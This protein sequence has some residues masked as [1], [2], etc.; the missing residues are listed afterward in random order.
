MKTLIF[1]LLLTSQL[2]AQSTSPP[3]V[4]FIGSARGIGIVDTIKTGDSLKT[5]ALKTKQ[6]DNYLHIENISGTGADTFVVLNRTYGKNNILLDEVQIRGTMTYDGLDYLSLVVPQGEKRAFYLNDR[7]LD[8]LV[9]KRV[10]NT[11]VNYQS[12]NK[13][14][15]FVSGGNLGGSQGS[16][17]SSVMKRGLTTE[18]PPLREGEIFYATDSDNIYIGTKNGLNRPF[19]PEDPSIATISVD[20]VADTI[21]I[22]CAYYSNFYIELYGPDKVFYLENVPEWKWINILVDNNIPG[23]GDAIFADVEFPTDEPPQ[24]ENS[25]AFYSFT[26]VN[27]VLIGA[28]RKSYDFVF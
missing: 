23:I 20:V 18:I 19:Y 25:K 10:S 24:P 11:G 13:D 7:L 12:T 3:K 27:G 21:T 16:S 1:L 22:D 17:G 6:T 5:I 26:K 2:F 28:S 9:I 8:V 4:D 14:L 15:F